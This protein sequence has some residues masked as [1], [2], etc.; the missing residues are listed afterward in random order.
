MA[1]Q[2]LLEEITVVTAKI[3]GQK[4]VRCT[5]MVLVLVLDDEDAA[6]RHFLI[7]DVIQVQSF[8]TLRTSSNY[9][10]D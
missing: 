8:E 6:E 7:I 2:S 9:T 5:A 4:R 3:N 10:A 1:T